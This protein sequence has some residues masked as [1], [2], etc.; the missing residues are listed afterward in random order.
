[1]TETE[2][3]TTETTGSPVTQVS[4]DDMGGDKITQTMASVFDK[5]NPSSE[6]AKER[7]LS[8]YRK[9]VVTERKRE[10]REEYTRA[11]LTV[12]K[13]S[14]PL[15]RDATDTMAAIWEKHN[16]D[17]AAE[18]K[19]EIAPRVLAMPP[20]RGGFTDEQFREATFAWS[21]LSEA[22]KQSRIR[23]HK[24]LTVEAKRLGISEDQAERVSLDEIRARRGVEAVTDQNEYAPLSETAKRLYP[25]HS[26]AEVA[27]RFAE[28][29]ERYETNP[30]EVI[31]ELAAN[32]GIQ[33]G[34]DLES[35]PRVVQWLD[36]AER[37]ARAL[38]AQWET[39]EYRQAEDLRIAGYAWDDFTKLNPDAVR[40]QE[41]M[42][43]AI[44]QGFVRWHPQL[45]NIWA[46][47]LDYVRG[48]RV[49][50]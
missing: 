18:A 22:E 40:Y 23:E 13:D 47:A 46:E 39:P 19:G 35:N 48:G 31:Q 41:A 29:A 7:T 9:H 8:D 26:K 16:D 49:A 42:A 6:P 4:N 28:L 12:P 37:A 27:A 50:A 10:E 45:K 20:L 3:N 2:I 38:V 33:L 15:S 1:M 14:G 30:Q 34:A 24:E 44:E 11:G 21:K 36:N 32:K 17:G 43:S 25:Q 5:L